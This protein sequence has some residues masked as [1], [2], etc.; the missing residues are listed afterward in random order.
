MTTFSEMDLD[1]DFED[2]LLE[3]VAFQNSVGTEFIISEYLLAKLEA[4]RHYVTPDIYFRFNQHFFGR[5]Q[6]L[7]TLATLIDQQFVDFMDF[8]DRTQ[9]EQHTNQIVATFYQEKPHLH[10]DEKLKVSQLLVVEITN[11][12][13]EIHAVGPDSNLLISRPEEMLEEEEDWTDEQKNV[14]ANR[15]RD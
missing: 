15:D 2:P 12:F 1:F 5:S 8:D 11:T 7:V 9:I 14:Q 10:S 4:D 3:Y 13:Q 6:I